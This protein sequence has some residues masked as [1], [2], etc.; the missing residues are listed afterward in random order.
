MALRAAKQ[1]YPQLEIHFVCRERFSESAKRV[2]WIEKVIVLPTE[3]LVGPLLEDNGREAEAL[4]EL[5]RW[6]APMV[7]EPWDLLMNWTYSDASSYLTALLPARIKLGYTRR[8]DGSVSCADGWSHYILGAVQSGVSQNIHV[9]DILTTQLLT[10]LQIHV[11]DPIDPGT[12]TVTSKSFFQLSLKDSEIPFTQ[13]DPGRKWVGIQLSSDRERDTIAPEIWAKAAHYLVSRHPEVR[14]LLLGTASHK[15]AEEKFMAEIERLSANEPGQT[16][17][18]QN[19]ILSYIG[20]ANFDLWASL[21]GRCQWIMAS[22]PTSLQLASVLG[23]RVLYAAPMGRKYQESGPYGNGH[24][25]VTPKTEGTPLTAEAIYG[26]WTYGATEWA[27][28]R[29]MTVESHFSQLGFAQAL[30]QSE[31]LRSKIRNT[32][33]GG[34]VAYETLPEESLSIEDWS[35]Q[36]VGHIARA[37]YCGWTPP[38][39]QEIQRGKIRPTLVKSL[40]TV[41]ESVDVLIK[42]C[43][44]GKRTALEMKEKALKLKSQKLMDLKD[45]AEIQDLG[46]KLNEINGLLARL[47]KAQKSLLFFDQM[48]KVVMHNLKGE[49]LS[50]LSHETAECYQMLGEGARSTKYWIKK[51]LEM[52]RPQAVKQ[53]SVIAFKEGK[54]L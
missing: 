8:K 38:I 29:Q 28:R 40:R 20:K 23:T 1:L 43:D 49:A 18:A 30:N 41:D 34:G 50:E 4:A 35:S 48:A 54:S 37:W 53:A 6:I 46:S 24:Y 9:T 26:C 39:G 19:S 33:D 10:A 12:A 22:D 52:A 13:R 44:E 32:Q 7:N 21:V 47:G 25:V 45:R 17:G 27:H 16:M 42:I 11:G 36:V 51:T 3:K 31:V 15:A 5:A 2:P 14:V